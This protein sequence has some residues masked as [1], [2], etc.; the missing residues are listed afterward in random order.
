MR[1]KMFLA[2]ARGRTR[3]PACLL[4]LALALAGCT[5]APVPAANAPAADGST[6][7]HLLAINDFHGNLQPPT[8]LREPNA[9]A[10]PRA[11]G[12]VDVLAAY[13][14][15]YRERHP[16]AIV[17]SA[18]DL[19]GASPLVSALFRD[20]GT[21]EAMNRLGL[22]V[23]AVGNHEFDDGR[24]ELLRLARGGCHPSGTETCRG[25]DV[26][27]PVPFEG[28]RFPFL[29]ANV[30]DA[31]TGDTLFPPY[32]VR[33][34][35]GR[36]IAFIGLTL[37][38]TPA[39]VDRAGIAGLDFLPEADTINA[40]VPALRAQGIEAIVVLLHEGGDVTGPRNIGNLDGCAGDLAGSPVRAIVERLDDEIDL[41]VSGHTHQAYV[42]R[43][44]NATG[45][46]VPVTS[47]HDYGRVV[48]EIALTLDATGEVQAV[49]AHNVPVL[50]D[51]PG[52]VPDARLAQLVAR[53]AALAQ[54]LAERVVGRIPTALPREVGA[55]G[56]SP[57]GRVIADS[58]RAATLDAGAQVA[59]MNPGGIRAGIDFASGPAGEGEGA[60]TY[61]E[62]FTVQPF[63][64]ALVTM[65]LT[66]AQLHA[67]LEQQFGGCAAGAVAP[68]CTKLLQVSSGFEYAWSA[69]APVGTR[70]AFDSLRLDGVALQRDACYRVTVNSFLAAG[71][72][73]F[74]VL[75]DG[76]DRSTGMLD[77]LAME[78]WLAVPRAQD[79]APRVRRL[80]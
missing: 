6:Q 10:A 7:V 47:A 1:E 48:T 62:L 22:D 8:P 68:S 35:G 40:L 46:P 79:T 38:G 33:E 37:Q 21:I 30:R 43:L 55:N 29:A 14:R 69:G 36:R 78:R 75:R 74:A 70:V 54:P 20:E 60:V 58:Q 19:V 63:A 24:D 76:E 67:L 5:S 23:N 66:G 26:G 13:V 3:L 17:V 27:T 44:P 72:D 2:H 52:I 39:I 56:E 34:A 49:Q 71:G 32:L 80:P 9:D 57:L 50:R 11:V 15:A 45:R 42:C 16:G 65:T 18:G 31:A 73:G 25:A 28:A 41:V 4:L 51:A 77:V 61:G 64:N 53:Y 59:F 12:G